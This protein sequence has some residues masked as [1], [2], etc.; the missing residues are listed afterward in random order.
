M[1]REFLYSF[2]ASYLW[3]S[4]SVAHLAW[5]LYTDFHILRFST[6]A[7]IHGLGWVVQEYAFHR[8]VLHRLNYH[9]EHHSKWNQLSSMFAS[10]FV[11]VPVSVAY[12]HGVY[13]LFGSSAVTYTF[14][15]MPI[16]YL[17]FEWVHYATHRIRD[18]DLSNS[19]IQ[20]KQYHR[21]HHRDPSIHY[22]IT[23]PIIDWMMGT[24]C[25]DIRFGWRD[26]IFAIFPM[27]WFY[28]CSTSMQKEKS[29]P[30]K[31]TGFPISSTN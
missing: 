23:S 17:A 9:A 21:T 10:Q 7:G 8:I 26:C 15:V 25:S 13:Y 30:F 12:Y 24:L 1:L 29:I 22:G 6:Y 2:P 28:S 4:V 5:C 3:L 19:I 31:F 18:C 11:I 27:L 14:I 20:V 16:Y